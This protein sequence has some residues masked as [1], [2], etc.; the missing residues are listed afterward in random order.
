MSRASENRVIGDTRTHIYRL[1]R[2]F[3]WV[4]LI[5]LILFIC[6]AVA[7]PLIW[8]KVLFAVIAALG[9][10]IVN[11]F[12]ML[13]VTLRP[14]EFAVRNFWG[15]T[16]T[17]RYS[18]ITGIEAGPGAVRLHIGSSRV[19]I[20]GLY[21]DFPALMTFIAARYRRQCGGKSIP[22]AP[23]RRSKLDVFNGNV[24]EPGVFVFVFALIA[25]LLIAPLILCR[26]AYRHYENEEPFYTQVSFAET[27]FSA[28]GDDLILR[29]AEDGLEYQIL[30]YRKTLAD[31]QSFEEACSSGT[32]F[33]VGYMLIGPKD[34]KHRSVRYVISGD[35]VFLDR[36]SMTRHLQSN[37][38]A[39]G[40]FMGA[41]L[42]LW[43]A[44]CA[45]SIWVG[46]HP[47]RFSRRVH[48]LF[49]KGGY[50]KNVVG[51]MARGKP[52]IHK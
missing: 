11:A 8:E 25:L 46:R 12:I 7:A 5:D 3:L 15:V 34:N 30:S 13:R 14:D 9:A 6:C 18:D 40:L 43:I 19:E 37:I 39:A 48:R 45:C 28:D 2:G 20:N 24:R 27:G 21:R 31:P 44:F 49:F 41:F 23:E 52:I 29:G 47:E 33:D 38:A 1:A 16:R 35:T 42:L 4:G 26:A 22:K 50:L 51:Y 10:V 32:V 17:Y 36:L